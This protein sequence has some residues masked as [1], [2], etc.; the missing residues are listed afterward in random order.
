MGYANVLQ[1]EY[2]YFV[3][4]RK[5]EEVFIYA[6]ARTYMKLPGDILVW[7]SPPLTYVEAEEQFRELK[8]LGSSLSRLFASA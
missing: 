6:K 8:W 4:C 3:D 1:D 5:D 7:V 2:V